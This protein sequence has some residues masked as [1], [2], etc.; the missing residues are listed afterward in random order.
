MYLH[1]PLNRHTVPA[2]CRNCSHCTSAE[3][4]GN[5]VTLFSFFLGVLTSD[6]SKPEDLIVIEDKHPHR[7]TDIQRRNHSSTA[8]Q[9]QAYEA[10]VRRPLKSRVV[11]ISTMSLQCKVQ[12]RTT[13]SRQSGGLSNLPHY[14]PYRS[15]QCVAY[16]RL[17]SCV[18]TT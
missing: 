12:R 9:Q 5:P 10:S 17:V 2:I 7:Q 8:Y 13:S 6:Y 3:R 4:A 18:Q 1:L 14:G 11:R 16:L 15:L